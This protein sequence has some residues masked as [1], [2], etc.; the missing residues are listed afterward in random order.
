MTIAAQL[1]MIR[2]DRSQRQAGVAMISQR[3]FRVRNE[4]RHDDP[5]SAV[6]R[7][8]CPPGRT[9]TPASPSAAEP[10]PPLPRREQGRCWL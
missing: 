5:W 1:R 6:A 4:R 3:G 9:R 2:S 7:S 8:V 10:P